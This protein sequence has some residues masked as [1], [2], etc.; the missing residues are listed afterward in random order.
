MTKPN[1]HNPAGSRIV[2]KT[3]EK[4]S[5]QAPDQPAKI[6]TSLGAA[7]KKKP[8]STFPQETEPTINI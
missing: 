2:G 8:G 3:I 4:S 6:D 1:R 7:Q 5:S